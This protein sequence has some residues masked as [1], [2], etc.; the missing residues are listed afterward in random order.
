MYLNFYEYEIKCY[1]WYIKY[2][3]MY[4]GPTCQ[5]QGIPPME[6]ADKITIA[7]KFRNKEI[8]DRKLKVLKKYKKFQKL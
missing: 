2:F 6:L 8:C 5:E 1:I 3:Q 4:W 7:E